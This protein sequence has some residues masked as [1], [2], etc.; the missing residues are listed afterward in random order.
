[1]KDTAL[2]HKPAGFLQANIDVEIMRTDLLLRG[3]GVKT[4]VF[5]DIQEEYFLIHSQHNSTQW[6]LTIHRNVCKLTSERST[7]F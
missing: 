3:S 7:Y 5:S 1:M 6:Q 2:L 4:R